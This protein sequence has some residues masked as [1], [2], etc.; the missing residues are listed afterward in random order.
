LDEHDE[1]WVIGGAQIFAATLYRT[2]ELYIT[3][4]DTDLHCDTFYPE[5]TDRFELQT[6]GNLKEENGYPFRFARYVT[7]HL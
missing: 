2:D 5:Y 1:V 6:S 4:I 7:K 3:H